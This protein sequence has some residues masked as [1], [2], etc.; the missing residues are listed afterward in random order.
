V[1]ELRNVIE[2]VCILNDAR[3]FSER[4]LLACLSPDSAPRPQAAEIAAEGPRPDGSADSRLLAVA[5]R[6]HIT[7]VLQ[8]TKGNKKAAAQLLGV[9]RR[10]LYRKLD[11]LGLR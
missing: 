3:F 5:E 9:S 7:R 11:R 10:A 4:E 1:R 6:D 8:D 2:R